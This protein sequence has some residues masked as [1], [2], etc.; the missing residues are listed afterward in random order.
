MNHKVSQART[1]KNYMNDW[2]NWMVSCRQEFY[3]ADVETLNT[4]NN[5]L[6]S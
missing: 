4:L 1:R 5:S 3:E 6:N 2:S